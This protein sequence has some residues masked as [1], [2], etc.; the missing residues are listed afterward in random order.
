MKKRSS[1]NKKTGILVTGAGGFIGSHLL[2]RLKN[3]FEVFCV[4]SKPV[5]CQGCRSI[6]IDLRD[7]RSVRSYF[8]RFKK[9]NK[10]SV[11]VHLAS[12]LASVENAADTEIFYDNI[13]ITEGVVE[14]ARII[15]PRKLI[16]FSSIAVYPN[17]TGKF[18]EES[19]VHPAENSDCLYGLSKLC[20]ENILDF[21][22]GDEKIK[23]IHL[24]VAQV[25]GEGMRADRIIPVMLRE[26]KKNNTIT[27]FGNGRRS[28]SFIEVKKLVSVIH[29][30]I[31]HDASGVINTGDEQL[32]LLAL[33]RKLIREYGDKRSRI[34]KKPQGPR[35]KFY[36]VTKKLKTLLADFK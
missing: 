35:E 32:S 18:S 13:R 4:D 31:T 12:R 9:N 29:F 34:I 24:R 19:P 2:D 28:I 6:K 25:Y 17:K 30:F 8:G 22:L 20:S 27:V 33:A 1:G 5:H 36:L 16:H 21:L 11:I 26:L 3:D 10:V 14:M 7:L 15:K 23:I